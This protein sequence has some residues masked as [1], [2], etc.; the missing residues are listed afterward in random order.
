M[1][2]NRRRAER[3]QAAVEAAL[4]LPLTV[5]LMLGTLQLFLMLQARLMAEHAV[6][7]ATRAG[8]LS[9]GYCPRMLQ[10]AVTTLLPTFARTDNATRLTNAFSAHKSNNYT[11]AMDGQLTG[12]I[13]WL[14]RPRPTA[15][16]IPGQDDESWDDPDQKQIQRLEVR[17][18][19]W[20]PMRIPFANWLIAHMVLAAWGI[21]PFLAVNPLM[22]AQKANWNGT[23]TAPISGT[24]LSEFVT[25]T[26]QNGTYVFPIVATAAMRM[27]TPPRKAFFTPQDCK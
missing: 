5:F 2:L 14:L 6:Y 20:Y 23:E 17:M 12:N 1:K 4:T 19:F 3:G 25:R 15:G 22:P 27:M 16:S 26:G 11:A 7:K 13:V 24:I 18:V 8:S 10:A 9:Q 21:Q